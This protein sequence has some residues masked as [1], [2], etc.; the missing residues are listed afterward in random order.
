[1]FTVLICSNTFLANL[2]SE[3]SHLLDIV[4]NNPNCAICP[5]FA[6]G[7]TLEQAVPDLDKIT[8]GRS[9][10]RALVILDA[11]TFGFDYINRR[12]PFDVVDAT[13]S[14]QSFNDEKIFT[15]LDEYTDLEAL[16]TSIDASEKEKIEKIESDLAKKRNDIEARIA[17]SAE[18]IK[19]HRAKMD[20]NFNKS[21]L[22]PLTQLAIWMAGAPIKRV[23]EVSPLWPEELLDKNAEINWDYYKKLYELKLLP[24]ELEQYHSDCRKFEVLNENLLN[25]SKLKKQPS[26]IIALSERNADRA[27]DIFK[28]V[29][30]P[31]E[32]IEYSS[33]C[34]VNLYPGSMRFVLCDVSYENNCRTPVG[35]LNLSSLI[36]MMALNE[37]PNGYLREERIY[38]ASV[39]INKG[40]ARHFFTQYLLK[41]N[42]TK[43]MLNRKLYNLQSAITDDG[44]LSQEEAIEIFESDAD[45]PVTIRINADRNEYLSKCDIGLTKD[46]PRDEYNHWY[47]FVTETTRKFI[48]YLREPRRAVKNAAKG[49]FRVQSVI[50]DERAFLLDED[51]LED[52]QYRLQEEELQMIETTTN[53]LYETKSYLD[54][55]EDADKQVRVGIEKRM[56]RKHALLCGLFALLAFGFGFIPL[57]LR[58]NDNIKTIF[59]TLKIT[60]ISLGLLAIAA[61][62]FLFVTRRLQVKLMKSF[63]QTMLAAFDDIENG[64]KAFSRYLSHACNVMRAFSVFNFLKRPRECKQDVIKKH[65][66]DIQM[67]I[68]GINGLFININEVDDNRDVLPYDFDFSQLKDYVYDVP[69]EEV[70]TLVRFITADNLVTVP[71]DYIVSIDLTMEE[72]YD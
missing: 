14:L 42:A 54:K 19:A 65:L 59:T 6:D 43:R 29:S 50:D 32:E 12:N 13:K 4:A 8:C 24:S 1:M 38:N 18:A 40:K 35:F 57:I 63:N 55:M 60:G 33:F 23:P 30:V 17:Q 22:Q 5:W 45:V 10:W 52:I 9:E 61:L 51:R 71:I 2:K 21:A 70:D 28:E 3:H 46:C 58:N 69:Y 15:L 67:K 20:A 39:Q 64:L 36:F 34:D 47:S 31:H 41:L 25:S 26:Q 11:D 48:R 16:L 68:D 66:C 56:T 72:L 27:D 37:V 62:V 7:I 44:S 49:E 53:R